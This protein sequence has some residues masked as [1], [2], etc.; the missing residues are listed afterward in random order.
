MTSGENGKS[1]VRGYFDHDAQRYLRDRYPTTA[2]TC[3][4]LSYL[5]RKARVLRLLDEEAPDGQRALDI[6]CGPGVFLRELRNRHWRS[7]AIDLSNGMLRVAREVVN[8]PGAPPSLFAL[9][10]ATRLPFQTGAFGAV[11]CIGVLSYVADVREALAEVARVLRPGGFAIF[12]ISNKWSPVDWEMRVT[13]FVKEHGWIAR[14][15]EDQRRVGIR[16]RAYAP[17]AFNACC[18]EAGF[19]K[20]QGFYYDYRIPLAGR[21]WPSAALSVGRRL[22]ALD[23][24]SRVARLG[25]GYVLKV[26]K[27]AGGTG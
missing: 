21:L 24:A 19:V 8:D 20:G 1:A 16:L 6:G 27:A 17:A 9:A 25:G 2:K 12:Q 10:E 18:E 11:L 7:V 13:R 22:D 15:D 4:E 14:D 26:R 5:A 23:T 3:D